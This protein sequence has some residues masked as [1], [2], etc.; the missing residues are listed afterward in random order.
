M[1]ARAPN[2]DLSSDVNEL[3]VNRVSADWAIRFYEFTHDLIRKCHV[4]PLSTTVSALHAIVLSQNDKSAMGCNLNPRARIAHRL[5][6]YAVN[7]QPRYCDQCARSLVPLTVPHVKRACDVC[8]KEV[9]VVEPGEGGKGVRLREGDKFIIPRGWLA[10]SLDPTKARGRFFRKG[11]TW[12]VASLIVPQM[13]NKSDD[14]VGVFQMWEDEADKI[15]DSSEKLKHLNVLTDEEDAERAIK[16]IEKDK[17]SLE[18]WALLASMFSHKA[19]EE[20]EGGGSPET[21]FWAM[22]AASAWAMLVYHRDLERHVWTGYKH[23]QLVYD[24]ASAT[25]KTPAEAE[26]IKALRPA[27]EN[28][29]EDVLHVWVESESPIG[30][31][32]NVSNIDESLLRSLAKYHLSLFE[33]QR[34]QNELDRDYRSRAWNHRIQGASVVGGLAVAVVTVLKATG[35][36]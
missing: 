7:Q 14:L 33:R 30:P 9:H 26:I 36:L 31:R 15:L 35:V 24:I 4:C 16:I 21:P 34:R 2:I 25:A 32:L 17:D 29:S 10:M 11:V 12:F 13:P 3:N 1:A 20:I 28:L 27:F 18:W 5:H 6:S 23:N 8:G 22:R 19:R